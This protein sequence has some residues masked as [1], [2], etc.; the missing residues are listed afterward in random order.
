MV[1]MVTAA[2]GRGLADDR[3]APFV[4]IHSYLNVDNDY[5]PHTVG[6]SGG[7]TCSPRWQAATPAGRMAGAARRVAWL[8]VGRPLDRLGLDVG[9]EI[10]QSDSG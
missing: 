3:V 6:I 9:V 4:Q 10:G 2:H 1:A 5:H 7:P 8:A